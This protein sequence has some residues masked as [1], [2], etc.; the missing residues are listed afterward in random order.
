LAKEESANLICGIF[1]AISSRTRGS[2]KGDGFFIFFLPNRR[3][4][5]QMCGSRALTEKIWR[6]AV[7]I[8][9]FWRGFGEGA[10]SIGNPVTEPK[11]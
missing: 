10:G 2:W 3:V 7:R 8:F 1:S 5:A 9:G 4:P 6:C 11:R